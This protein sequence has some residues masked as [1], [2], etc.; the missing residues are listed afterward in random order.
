MMDAGAVLETLL[1]STGPMGLLVYILWT[2]NRETQT[3]VREVVAAVQEVG[4]SLA[5]LVDRDRHKT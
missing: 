1:Q 5:V 2:S 4:R 3:Q